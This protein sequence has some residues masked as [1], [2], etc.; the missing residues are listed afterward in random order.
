MFEFEHLRGK[1]NW[2]IFDKHLVANIL[3]IVFH[4]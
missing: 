4:I 1:T 3:K 2:L